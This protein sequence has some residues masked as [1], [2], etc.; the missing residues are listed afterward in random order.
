MGPSN[1]NIFTRKAHLQT[2]HHIIADNR[3][4]NIQYAAQPV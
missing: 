3:A 4:G 1:F 2:L